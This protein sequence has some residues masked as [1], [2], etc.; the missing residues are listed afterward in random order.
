MK[1]DIN[2][3]KTAILLAN[4]GTPDNYD[5]ITIRKY[6]SEFLKDRRII[7]VN[8]LV[9]YPLLYGII[10]NT[11]PFKTQKG[12]SRIWN[13]NGCIGSP[14]LHYT[15]SI[16]HKLDKKLNHAKVYFGMRYGSPNINDVVKKIIENGHEK[17]IVL[18]LFPQYSAT[19]VGSIY[20][21]FFSSMV[22]IR[23]L[24]SVEVIKSYNTHPKYI[25]A[26]ANSINSHLQKLSFEP[27]LLLASFHGIPESYC[28]KGDPYPKECEQTIEALKP[29]IGKYAERIKICYQS[30]FGKAEWIK[31][32]TAEL[33]KHL[34]KENITKIA[35][36][37]PGFFTD[38]LETID[39]IGRELQEDFIQAGGKKFTWISCIND[40]NDGID[41][42]K[43]ICS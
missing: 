7:E 37:S 40:N 3:P 38:C 32:Y 20:D 8:K 21:K 15:Q 11:R 36:F 18:T 42:L 24:P 6:L 19:T 41:L 33:V 17:I 10:L 29:L 12:Y 30:R 23:N 26:L 31:P 2:I 34:P 9:W 4:L 13:Y 1:P 25:K 35:I 39:E 43:E 27:E 16:A 14:L 5:F 28:E 22:N